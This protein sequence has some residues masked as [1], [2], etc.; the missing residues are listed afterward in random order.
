[1]ILDPLT[2]GERESLAEDRQWVLD[3]IDRLYEEIKYLETRL[4]DESV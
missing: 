3:Y 1:M 4:E 2:A